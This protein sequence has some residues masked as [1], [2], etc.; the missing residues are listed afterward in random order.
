MHEGGEWRM[1]NDTREGTHL[2][3]HLGN[4]R[5]SREMEGEKVENNV[6]QLVLR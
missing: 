2:S 5:N 4:W 6:L 3:S 1:K